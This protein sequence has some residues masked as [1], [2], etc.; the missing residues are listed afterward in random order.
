MKNTIQPL[1]ILCSLGIAEQ[2]IAD[3][4]LNRLTKAQQELDKSLRLETQVS[5][6]DVYSKVEAF[7]INNIEFPIEES[8]IEV[9][10][11]VLDNDFLNDTNIKKIKADVTGRCLGPNGIWKL[12][13]TL[14]DYFIKSGYITTR[15]EVPDQDLSSKKLVLVVV[16]GRIEDII[17][18]NNDVKNWILPFKS[19]QILNVRDLEQGVETLQKVPSLNVKID[20][21]PGNKNGFSHVV[22]DTGR[23]K[24]WNIRAW[25]NNWGDEGTGQNLIGGAAYLYNLTKMNDI[26][27]LSGTTNAEHE[28]GRYKSVSAYYSVPFGYWDFDLFY[29]KSQSRQ[30]LNIGPFAF[31]Y[32]GD[33]EYSSL[34]ASRTV[35][36]DTDKK[37]TL[38]SELFHRKVSN[39]LED[40][41]LVLQKRDMTNL[42]FGLNLKKNITGALLD[43]TLT[44]Q[45]FIP[46]FGAKETPDMKTGDV[47]KLSNVF[48]FDVDYT[49]LLNNLP[50]SAYY[51]LKLGA[52]FSP[53]SLTVQDRFT[54]GDRW[55]VRG[56]ESTA[57]GLDGDKGAY[58]QNTI[59]IMTGFKNLEWFFGADY[60]VVFKDK[61][62]N[63][64]HKHLLGMTTGFKGYFKSFGY[65][66]SVSKPLNYPQA[67][68]PDKYNV[69]F[70][71]FYQL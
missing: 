37:I 70:N 45:R 21:E 23:K 50:V 26:F 5:K 6:K 39:R 58:A 29:S 40:I 41:E 24:N 3:V 71:I 42:R 38:S 61:S 43:T 31:N 19:D 17:I 9:D 59:S 65:G 27:S 63:L 48:N 8:C 53:H 32:F 44:Y 13:S 47:S 4:D 22:I 14:Q 56:F 2:V 60:G 15:V 10:E 51:N 7:T 68:S 64:R 1:L 16:P 11:L 54:I 62:I 35:Y 67:L 28:T 12:A 18:K 66:I 69:N 25:A 36:R 57:A 33:T 30:S 52:Q 49:K 20:I 55:S 34:K 46:W